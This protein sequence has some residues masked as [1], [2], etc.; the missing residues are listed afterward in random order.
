MTDASNVKLPAAFTNYIEEHYYAQVTEQSKLDAVVRDPE[1]LKNPLKHV[2]LFSDHG[3]LHGRDIASKITQV[4]EQIHGLLIPTRPPARLEFM[5][6]YGAML[7]YLHDMGM[8]NFSAFGRSMHPEFAAQLM[9]TAE[10]DPW[11]DLLWRENAGSVAWRLMNLAISG[12]IDQP[13][14]VLREMLALSMAHSKSKV[15]IDIL[16]NVA[17][18]KQTMQQCVGTELH[19]LYY[20]QQVAI[21]ERKL[22]QQTQQAD[23]DRF[24]QQL[25]KAQTQ[26]AQATATTD[27]NQRRNQEIDR[28][29]DQFEQTAFSWLVADDL[30]VQ[31]LTLDAID[32]VRALRCADALRQRGT[33]FTTSAGYE[34]FVSKETAN[35]VYALQ[36][37]NSV[38]AALGKS[39]SETLPDRAQLFLLE[40][41][42]PISA[43]EANMANSTLDRE[44][45]LRLAFSTGAFSSPEATQWAAF[46]A[47]VVINDIQADVIGS[48][49]RSAQE[50]ERLQE[51][52]KLEPEMQILIE[53]V[54][55]NP[56]FANLISQELIQLNPNLAPRI[57]TITSLQNIGLSQVEQYLSGTQLNW[58]TSEKL[59][60]LDRLVKTGHKVDHID[61]DRAFAEVRLISLKAGEVLIEQGVPSGFVYIPLQAGL[62]RFHHNYQ[63]L[64]MLPYVPVNDVEV[65]RNTA[66]PAKI[67]AE[68]TV[69]LLMI[70]KQI[71]SRYWYASYTVDEFTQLFNSDNPQPKLPSKR[72]TSLEIDLQRVNRRRRSLPI[73]LHLMKL[74]PQSKQLE[75]FMSYLE[76]IQLSEG[77]F[78]FREGDRPKALYF[79]EFGQITAETQ[80]LNSGAL[81]GGWEFYS[82]IAYPYSAVANRASG[83]HCLSTDALQKMQ[84]ESPQ[85]ATIFDQY[86]LI[87]LAEE[88]KQAKQEITDLR[89]ERS[90]AIER[91]VS[92]SQ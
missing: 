1:F 92:S 40:G 53:G 88:I 3:I 25:A 29:Y 24:A 28:Y 46:S 41:K 15:P 32:T 84:D 68:Q 56:E 70:P 10:F 12:S 31:Q 55:D 44:G 91:M 14:L 57:Q 61:L 90:A 23:L 82:Q 34:V 13:Q 80:T 2:A 17:V 36:R 5:L 86:L 87:F 22:A 49:R 76:E 85:I 6:G 21:A 33:T 54:D 42:D 18:L 89:Q 30:E 79:V 83:L 9:F 81:I 75:Q 27:A 58:D 69:E 64:T 20:Q 38:S 37:G 66:N 77:D 7:A 45:N 50:Q 11:I 19:Y 71:Y 67:V 43:G 63:L 78:L 74:F 39:V 47:A 8:K 72:T 60:L 52:I 35:A 62:K 26:L 16:N 51:A 59:D 4:I 48:F 65:I 73:A